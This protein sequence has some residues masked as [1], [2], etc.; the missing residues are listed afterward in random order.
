MS[1]ATSGNSDDEED[2][3]GDDGQEAEEA[4]QCPN[5]EEEEENTFECDEESKAEIHDTLANMWAHTGF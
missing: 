2:G 5:G 4:E 1:M 3:E